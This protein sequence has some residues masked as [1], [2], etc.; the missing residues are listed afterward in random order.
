MCDLWFFSVPIHWD[1]SHS[2]ILL[3][4]LSTSGQELRDM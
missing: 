1:T 4:A 3:P 2:M